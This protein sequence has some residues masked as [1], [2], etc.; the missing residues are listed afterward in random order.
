MISPMTIFGHHTFRVRLYMET[1]VHKQKSITNVCFPNTASAFVHCIH[2]ASCNPYAVYMYI[3]L[4]LAWDWSKFKSRSCM[5]IDMVDY[6]TGQKFFCLQTKQCLESQ[7]KRTNMLHSYLVQNH[8]RLQ[9]PSVL[10]SC[11]G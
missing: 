3:A 5:S 11:R 2:K 7:T 1:Q 8:C 9:F 6:Q 10:K 4:Y